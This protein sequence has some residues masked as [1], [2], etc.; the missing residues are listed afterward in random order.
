MRNTHFGGGGDGF[1]K[2]RHAGNTAAL[3]AA[4]TNG[5]VFEQIDSERN[6]VS[7]KRGAKTTNNRNEEIRDS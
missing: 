5:G 6:K 4:A 2:F 1:T 7:R 3:F